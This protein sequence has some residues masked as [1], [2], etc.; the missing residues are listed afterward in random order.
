MGD[1][2]KIQWTDATWNPVVGC[3]YISRG[4]VNCY[5]AKQARRIAMMGNQYE[6]YSPLVS[7]FWDTQQIRWQWSGKVELFSER[8]DQPLR[9]RKPRMVF[10]CSMGD[11]F[12][13]GVSDEYIDR[14]WNVMTKSPKH[15]FQILTK[16]P[17]R[18]RD[19][20]ERGRPGHGVPPNVWLGVSTENQETLDDRVPYLLAT[21]AAVRFVSAEPLLAKLNLREHLAPIADRSPRWPWGRPGIDWVIVGGESGPGA[22]HCNL[23]W[24]KWILKQCREADVPCFVKQ[25]GA[26]VTRPI[27]GFVKDFPFRPKHPKGGDPEEWP[28]EL[29][30]REWPQRS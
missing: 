22:R 26:Y 6:R 20:V 16:R 14:V 18:M 4:C 9:W 28:E 7:N 24:I 11:L 8:L 25:V 12:H 13:E 27:P 19:Y 5:A 15:T 30:V 10:V 2:S 21:P 17:A 3:T 29:R 23:L 1:K